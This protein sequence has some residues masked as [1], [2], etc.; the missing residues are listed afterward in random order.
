MCP[1]Y[2][3]LMLWY[4]SLINAMAGDDAMEGKNNVHE[5]KKYRVRYTFKS[6][7]PGQVVRKCYSLEKK[8]RS[9]LHKTTICFKDRIVVLNDTF[10]P[11]KITLLT[12]K[13]SVSSV[14][15]PFCVKN[16]NGLLNVFNSSKKEEI[17]LNVEA[18]GAGPVAL[19]NCFLLPRKKSL[20]RTLR[21]HTIDGK[22]CITMAGKGMKDNTEYIK[23]SNV[24]RVD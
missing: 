7:L 2:I 19:E 6:E 13:G 9:L 20:F 18:V 12:G 4:C 21:V 15:D 8:E 17:V 1:W 23:L 14:L 22:K 10:L 16:E 11:L 5:I 24:L 3:L